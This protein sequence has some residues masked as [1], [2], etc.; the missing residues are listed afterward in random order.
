M[1]GFAIAESSYIG[2]AFTS[3]AG[4]SHHPLV[5]SAEGKLWDP[6]RPEFVKLVTDSDALVKL[7][8]S[9]LAS[10]L[11]IEVMH[12]TVQALASWF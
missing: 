11:V 8:G 9:G 2:Q 6:L 7:L 10:G 1:L 3:E 5:P 4:Y 12:W